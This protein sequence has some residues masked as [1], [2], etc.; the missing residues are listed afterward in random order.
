M[1]EKAGIVTVVDEDDEVCE[2]CGICKIQWS[3][4]KACRTGCVCSVVM[5]V[6]QTSNLQVDVVLDIDCCCQQVFGCCEFCVE[7]T[8]YGRK[9]NGN[10]VMCCT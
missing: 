3:S 1:S 7:L 9:V 10:G 2:S 5:L 6:W 8:S 4:L